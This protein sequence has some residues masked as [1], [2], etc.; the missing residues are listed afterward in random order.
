[1]SGRP[2]PAHLLTKKVPRSHGATIM[3]PLATSG[4]SDQLDRGH[5]HGMRGGRTARG[6]DA[7]TA[8][9]GCPTCRRPGGGGIAGLVGSVAQLHG[10]PCLGDDTHLQED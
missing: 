8:A 3:V 10:N 2:A 6:R 4:R 9:E 5:M 1:M 7:K